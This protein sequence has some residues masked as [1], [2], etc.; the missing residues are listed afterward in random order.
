VR[1]AGVIQGGQDLRF[2]LEAGEPVG[3]PGDG[4]GQDLDGHVALQLR[5]RGPVDLA[6]AAG[7]DLRGDLI[8]TDTAAGCQRHRRRF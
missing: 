4:L 7:A 3:V 1:D 6:H 5:V 8:G 2:P